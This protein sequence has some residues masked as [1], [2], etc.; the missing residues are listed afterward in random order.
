MR[1]SVGLILVAVLALAACSKVDRPPIERVSGTIGTSGDAG[2]VAAG[3]ET[4]PGSGDVAEDG[5][6]STTA[7]TGTAGVAGSSGDPVTRGQAATAA[8]T[9]LDAYLDALESQDFKAAQRASTGGPS[10]MAGIRDV[11]ARYNAERDGTTKLSYSGRSFTVASNGENRVTFTGSASLGSTTSGPAGSPRSDASTFEDP[12][13]TFT[14]GSWRVA[15]YLFDG[16]PLAHFPATSTKSVGGV[17][18]R[19]R[20]GLSFGK[21]TA[22]VIDLVSDADHGIRVDDGKITYVDG[23]TAESTLGAL[24]S[25]RPAALYFLFDRASSKPASWSAAI[26]IDAGT[27]SERSA[28]VVLRF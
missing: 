24:I 3:N 1:R 21:L 4:T 28:N 7:V 14:A 26:T 23:T 18:L 12:V 16:A 15:D 9:A 25:K 19:L 2:S 17:D 11:V 22:L 10:F 8:T 13:V 27:K 5:S 6:N 20:G